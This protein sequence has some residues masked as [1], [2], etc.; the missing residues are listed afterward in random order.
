MALAAVWCM[1]VQAAELEVRPGGVV[2]WSASATELCR[3]G[4]HLWEP[5]GETCFYPADLEAG[6]EL[7]LWRRRAG[8]EETT[9]VR[10]GAYPYQEQRL[11]VEDRMVHL[12]AAD[13]RRVAREKQDLEA[14]WQL[15]TRA[16]FQLPVGQPLHAVAGEGNFGVRR[17]FNGEPRSP[18]GGVDYRAAAGT[19]V[20]AVAPGRV[21]LVADHFFAG[22]GIF[23]DHGGG[24]VSMY[25]HLSEA[26]VEVGR[27][28][29]AGEPLGR[30]GSSGRATGPH[31]HFAV[32]WHGARVDPLLLQ[33]PS[34]RLPV[35]A[36]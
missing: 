18:H 12:S 9:T 1:P 13:Q 20:V 11:E 8:R 4:E 17:V 29:A 33:G 35:V 19:T 5:L 2:R 10:V 23:V 34:E 27:V 30:V 15:E 14:I 24:L 6:G 21:V 25:F 36:P 3:L 7:T 32:R 16:R 26:L 31:L 28:V 22:L